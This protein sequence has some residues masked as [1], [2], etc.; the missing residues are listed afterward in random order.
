MDTRDNDTVIRL[1]R[2]DEKKATRKVLFRAF[3]WF[4]GVFSSFT[5]YTFIALKGN[6]IVGG[7]ILDL[8]TLPNRGKIGK[9]SWIFTDPQ[10]RGLKLG[11]RLTEKALEFFGEEGCDEQ[12]AAVEGNNTSSSKLFATRGFD[13]IS[14]GAQF[15]RYGGWTFLMWLKMFHYMTPGVFLWARPVAQKRDSPALQWTATLVLN[16]I[17]IS[18]I[19]SLTNQ[20]DFAPLVYYCVSFALLLGTRQIA[21]QITAAI[22]NYRV[23]FRIFESGFPLSFMIA[24]L[25]RGFFPVLGNVYPA[26]KV[27]KYSENIPQL[28]KIALSGILI[29]ALPIFGVWSYAQQSGT[30]N[31]FIHSFISIGIFFLIFDLLLFFFPFS[32]FNGKRLWDWNKFL[33]ALLSFFALVVIFL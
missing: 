7:A 3:G 5:P 20:G 17:I 23:R 14:P 4:Q 27:W 28:G 6:E 24:I 2:E 19:Y 29:V 15:R 8:F 26:E 25:L 1:M 10:A 16:L 12:I 33:W 31:M 32:G 18:L 30:S 13:I 11:Q 22:I 21:M 9:V